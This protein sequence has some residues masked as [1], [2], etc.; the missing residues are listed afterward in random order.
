MMNSSTGQ[1]P[2][3]KTIVVERAVFEALV[4]TAEKGKLANNAVGSFESERRVLRDS[5]EIMK[6]ENETLTMQLAETKQKLRTLW[7]IVII[8]TIGIIGSIWVFIKL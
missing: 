8:E 1:S 6:G 7:V 4:K 2:L 3:S 5:L